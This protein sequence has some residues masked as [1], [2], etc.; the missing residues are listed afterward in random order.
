MP[1][2]LV[3]CICALYIVALFA[4]AW[5][6]DRRASISRR[7]VSP[8]VYSLALAVYC[9]SWTFFGAVGTAVESGWNYLPIYLGPA[10]VFLFIPGLVQ[11]IGDITQRESIGSLSDFLAARYGKSRTLAASVTLAAVAGTVPYIALQLKSLA[12]SFNALTFGGESLAATNAHNTVLLTAFALGLFAILFGT[13]H[14]DTTRRNVGLM[15]VL[16]FEAVIKIVALAAVCL[17]AIGAIGDGDPGRAAATAS[18]FRFGGPVTDF[19]TMLILATAAIICLPRQFHVAMVERGRRDDVSTARWVF[20]AYLGVTSLLVVPIAVAGSAVLGTSYL[21]DLYVIGLP[22]SRGHEGIALLVFLG[23]LSAA[24]GMVVV[25]CIALSTMVTNDLLVPFLFRRGS[26]PPARQADGSSLVSMRRMVIIVLLLLAYGYYQLAGNSEA[27]ARIGLISFAAAI[28]FAPALL[29]AVYW[30]RGHLNGALGGLLGGMAIWLYTLLL[31]QVFG[32]GAMQA[33]GLTG[34]VDPQRLLA[35]DLGGPLTHGLI[36]SVGV[37]MLVYVTGSLR[38]TVRLRDRIQAGVFSSIDSGES[39]LQQPFPARASGVTPNGLKTLASRFLG[40][41]AVEA[42]FAQFESEQGRSINAEEPADWRLIQRTERL[43]ASVLGSASAR[44]VMSSALAGSA[45]A[46]NDVL[47][48]L[49]QQTQAQRF[50]RH[51]LQ[52]MLENISQGI[53]VVDGEQ[54]LVAWNSAYVE[55]FRYPPTLIRLGQ[56][57]GDLIAH[58]IERGWIETDDPEDE[59]H[60]RI[61][62]MRRGIRHHF[63]RR[64]PDGRWLRISGMPMPGGGY[65]STFTDITQDKAREAALI[66][67]ADTLEAR[68]AERTADLHQMARDLEQAR[69]AAVRANLSKTRF[70]AAAS[71]DLLQPLN[72]ARLFLGALAEQQDDAPARKLAHRVDQAISAADQLLRGLLDI[73]RLDQG[74]IEPNRV[75]IAA[76]D[77]LEALAEEARPMATAVGLTIRHVPTSLVAETDADFLRSILRNYLSNARRYTRS[78]RILMGAR[79]RGE[80]IRFE[81]WDT[82]PG[83]P[84]ERQHAIFEEFRRFEETDNTGVRGAGLGLAIV[85]RLAEAMDATVGVRSVPGKGSVFFVDVKNAGTADPVHVGQSAPAMLPERLNF[86]GLKVLCVDDEP[87][88]LDSM[89]MLLS[90]WGCDVETAR[91]CCDAL[92]MHARFLPH[93]LLLDLQLG[94]G[95]TGLDVV[96]ALTA[97][98][99]ADITGALITAKHDDHTLQVARRHG[100]LDVLAKPVDPDQLRSLVARLSALSDYQPGTRSDPADPP[101]AALNRPGQAAE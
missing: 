55:M 87:S 62:H 64:N 40:A 77:I 65:V 85:R 54:R 57:I 16:A 69:G 76:H 100:L 72:A 37:N 27:L 25:A 23:G 44:V 46:L 1:V 75:R 13:R 84:G 71:H 28:Q 101:A 60:N 26:R 18:Q 49:D 43:L 50:D 63:E 14:A 81:V 94:Q 47:S 82:G 6:G 32:A 73:S 11:R 92:A 4:I 10:L 74:D 21:P 70:L 83:I 56:P 20:P 2:W 97:Q 58:N 29:G 42:A 22:L 95:E 9:T 35:V 7:P 24:A 36:W 30:R 52:S 59:V 31:P 12:T 91:N 15:Q 19:T 78:G 67:A 61:A 80:M 89:R 68:V 34:L 39:S 33:A 51:M 79:R 86:P 93:I 17:I 90:A 5:H 66:E 98:T 45:V 99:G 88:V 38:A 53:S 3:I 96:D 48:I 41:D 8:L